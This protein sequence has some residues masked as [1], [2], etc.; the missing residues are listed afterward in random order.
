MPDGGSGDG[1]GVL[2]QELTTH[3]GKVRALSDR[4]KTAADAANQVT[5]DDGAFG[6]LC[7]PFA[8]ML[9]PFEEKG[10]AALREGQNALT[11]MVTKLGDTVKT[12]ESREHAGRSDFKGIEGAL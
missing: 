9:N 5:K 11:E 2:N 4:M 6:I 10:V 1:Y 3:A 8:W 7:R 12:Y